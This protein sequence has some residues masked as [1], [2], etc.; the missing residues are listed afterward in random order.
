MAADA[1]GRVA[2]TLYSGYIADGEDVRAFER[3]LAELTGAPHVETAGEYSAA[4][5]LALFQAGVRP[6][7]EVAAC[8]DA[9][10]GTNMPILNLFARPVWCDVD[11]TTG[12]I[13]PADVDRR[14]TPRTKAILFAHWG[15]DVAPLKELAAV[16]ERHGVAL[17]EDASEA[18]GAEYDGRWVGSTGLTDVTIWSFGPVRHVTTGEGAAAAFGDPEEAKRFRWLKRYGI[19]QPTFRDPDGE[20]D[21]ASDIPEPGINSYM[22]NIAA[23]IGLA[24]LERAPEAIAAHR[25]NGRFYDDALAGIPGIEAISRAEN[26]A[27]GYWVYTLLAERR[28]DLMRALDDAGIASSRLHLRNDTY[29]CFATGLADLPG[30]R[31]F[32]ARRLCVPCGW[33]VGE[34]ERERVVERIRA[35]W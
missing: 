4:I 25:A 7:D 26:T 13:D 29:S 35:G 27:S 31:D 14:I 16:A 2:D 5:A 20:I 3:G 18:F 32:S 10:L 24:Q 30:V 19:H 8:P 34:E 12:N 23:S 1:A 22:N 33:W 6:G 15:G 17:I 28:D 21:P 11:P 9:C